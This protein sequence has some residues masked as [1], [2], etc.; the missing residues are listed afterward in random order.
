MKYSNLYIRMK[1]QTYPCLSSG[2]R[3]FP[4][5]PLGRRQEG[6]FNG[7]LNIENTRPSSPIW[8]RGL[9]SKLNIKQV[10]QVRCVEV[11]NI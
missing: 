9:F 7:K 3:P 11:E 5:C 6:F 1:R 4:P 10:F 8:E 2:N